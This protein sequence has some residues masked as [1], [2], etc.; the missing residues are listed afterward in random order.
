LYFAGSLSLFTPYLL[1]GVN[2]I[3]IEFDIH[4][5]QI[6]IHPVLVL[7]LY[8]LNGSRL[9]QGYVPDIKWSKDWY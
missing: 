6:S 1:L 9:A 4:A 7:F 3:A 8:Y 5:E 2:E